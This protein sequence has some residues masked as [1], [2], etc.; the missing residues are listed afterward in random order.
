MD[1]I[2]NGQS[3][4][5]H[6]VILEGTR[7]LSLLDISHATVLSPPPSLTSSTSKKCQWQSYHP[8][9][10]AEPK[11]P[12]RTRSGDEGE[13]ISIGSPVGHS[14][15]LPL[16][17]GLRQTLI[18]ETEKDYREAALQQVAREFK[19]VLFSEQKNK[20]LVE[21]EALASISKK[22]SRVG[23]DDLMSLK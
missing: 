21:I 4:H 7:P 23:L 13:P 9:S 12:R 10:R 16:H 6:R 17:E 15:R 22:R 18:R 8:A 3:F 5:P 20:S 14:R 11:L 1:H 2:G 19:L